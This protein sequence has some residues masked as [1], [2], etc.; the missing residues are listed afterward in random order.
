MIVVSV[1][2]LKGGSAKT[3]TCAFIAHAFAEAGLTVLAVDA[4]GE[5]E[6]LAA[7]Q[8]EADWDIPVVGMAVPNLH[9]QLPG[10][11][12]DRYDA[13]VIDTPPMREHRG[14]VVSAM[15]V[16]THVVLPMAPTPMEYQRLPA[17]RALMDE[18][19]ELRPDGKPPILAVILT[20]CP[21]RPAASPGAFRD[22]ID[23]DGW[24]VL[25]A[26]VGR[27]ERFAQAHGDKIKNASRTPY[28][29]AVA[30]LLD[31]EVTV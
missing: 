29:D 28:G 5:N 22:L 8:A 15:R 25:N 12:G 3:T 24:H 10:V 13:V 17:V 21:P 19:T 20:R 1:V 16:A 9:R 2:N 4:D 18:V 30:E 27:N 26:Q 7:W 14:I 23:G 6:S 31:M 11:V